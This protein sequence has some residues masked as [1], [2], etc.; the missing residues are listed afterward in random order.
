MAEGKD[1]DRFP[2]DSNI[3]DEEAKL[4]APETEASPLVRV[5]FNR[6]VGKA[7]LALRYLL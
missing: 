1:E 5:V 3:F 6:A 4:Q 2:I 7:S